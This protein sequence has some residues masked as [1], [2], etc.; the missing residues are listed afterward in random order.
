LDFADAWDFFPR[1]RPLA[2]LRDLQ[3][4]DVAGTADGARIVREKE[5]CQARYGGCS[6]C[7]DIASVTNN[8][9]RILGEDFYADLLAEPE[10]VRR[11]LDVILQT[12]GHLHRFLADQFGG[13]DP[14]PIG[15]CNVSLMGPATYREMIFAYDAE[16]NRLAQRRSGA[17]PRAALHHC[18][19]PVDD[20][21]EAYAGLP[22]LASLQASLLSDIAAVRRRLPDCAF[23]ALVSPVMLDNLTILGPNLQRALRDGVADLAVW[24][25]D[26]GTA[27]A[28]LRAVFGLMQQLAAACGRQAQF[29]AMPLCWEELEWAHA[30]YRSR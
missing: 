4:V 23:S 11:L 25:I 22:G 9:F 30:R 15:N 13:M 2:E 24:N 8:A 17:P 3:P 16:Q 5:R 29:S 12:I 14:V 20:F 26:A 10:A 6:H 27:P 19:V 28:Q 7:L 18:D 1:H 21:L